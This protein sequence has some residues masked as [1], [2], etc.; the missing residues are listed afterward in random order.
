ML[1]VVLDERLQL[2]FNSLC[3]EYMGL[4]KLIKLTPLRNLGLVE[5]RF[6]QEL[7]L[8]RYS[9]SNSEFPLISVPFL[10]QSALHKH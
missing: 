1:S 9:V 2:G 10:D 8:R 5:V 7:R 3:K 6:Y 4:G